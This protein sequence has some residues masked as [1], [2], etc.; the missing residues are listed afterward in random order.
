MY[1]YC[2]IHSRIRE[3][4]VDG[5]HEFGVNLGSAKFFWHDFFKWY[6]LS[7]IKKK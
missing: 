2:A 5:L 7:T 3:K 1:E 4:F 6:N